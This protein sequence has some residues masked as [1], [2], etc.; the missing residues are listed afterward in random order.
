MKNIVNK[1][2]LLTFFTGH[3]SGN[4]SPE[5]IA[6]VAKNLGPNSHSFYF[7]RRKQKAQCDG[8]PQ[9]FS[10]IYQLHSFRN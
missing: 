3:V 1:I 2:H 6:N 9:K 8:F 4:I 5:Q 7:R 10:R